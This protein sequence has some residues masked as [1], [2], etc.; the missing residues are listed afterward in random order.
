M[1]GADGHIVLTGFE[2]AL[3]PLRKHSSVVPTTNDSGLRQ[4]PARENEYR[5]PEALLEW[6]EDEAVDSWSFGCL[7]YF[8]VVGEVSR[9]ASSPRNF[10]WRHAQHP[11]VF[12]F[13]EP[14]NKVLSKIL[15]SEEWWDCEARLELKDLISK[16]WVLLYFSGCQLIP[17]VHRV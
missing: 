1:I 14:R 7:V 4:V 12:E 17:T 2:Y 13:Q 3:S 5:A 11:F 9:H 8:L 15:F 10:F 6:T 16:V